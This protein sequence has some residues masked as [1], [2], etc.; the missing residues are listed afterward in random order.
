MVRCLAILIKGFNEF[1]LISASLGSY[2]TSNAEFLD[3]NTPPY[4]VYLLHV[5]FFII[6]VYVSVERLA[7]WN[8]T[9]RYKI[10]IFIKTKT[11]LQ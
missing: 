3:K 5:T 2:I 6:V 4:N 7:L 8:K 11:Q 1:D 9:P 10:L